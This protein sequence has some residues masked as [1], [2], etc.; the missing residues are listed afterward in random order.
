[1]VGCNSFASAQDAAQAPVA[2]V[3]EEGMPLG[4]Q[5]DGENLPLA[6]GERKSVHTPTAAQRN[7]SRTT[8]IAKLAEN[9]R[10]LLPIVIAKKASLETRQSARELADF[11]QRA[12]GAEF[13]ITTP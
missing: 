4:N 11:L 12:T 8:E 10:A 13:K 3:N 2:G 7:F 6:T 5:N 1:M 9:S